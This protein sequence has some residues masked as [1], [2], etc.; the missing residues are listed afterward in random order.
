MRIINDIFEF[1]VYLI[2]GSLRQWFSD[3]FIKQQNVFI[4]LNPRTFS[5]NATKVLL[6]TSYDFLPCGLLDLVTSF[7]VQKLI[8]QSRSVQEIAKNCASPIF[9][10]IMYSIFTVAAHSGHL[11]IIVTKGINKSLSIKKLHPWAIPVSV[12][13]EVFHFFAEVDVGSWTCC[14][15]LSVELPKLPANPFLFLDLDLLYQLPEPILHNIKLYKRWYVVVLAKDKR[16]RKCTAYLQCALIW[17]RILG[18]QSMA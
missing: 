16:Q 7:G 14:W 1:T 3:M 9:C 6:F 2:I 15:L 8:R 18:F 5:L 17:E 11:P 13:D 4:P 12:S 10:V